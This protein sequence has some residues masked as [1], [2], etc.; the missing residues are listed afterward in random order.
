MTHGLTQ[1]FSAFLHRRRRLGH[2]GRPALL[3]TVAGDGPFA[4]T[5]GH[6]ARDL[7][8]VACDD[9]PGAIA[10]LASHEGGLSTAEAAARL[11]RDGPNDV[12]HEKPLPWWLHL[13]HCYANPF[14]LLLT[15]LAVVSLA[16]D[17][18]KATVVIGVMVVLSTVVRFVQEGRSS[19][20]AEG[21]KVW[22]ATRPP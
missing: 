22:W 1:W 13:W 10:R 7:L 4:G 3:D 16:S 21:L 6:L 5:P 18:A 2:F 9:V 8:L 11:T 19:R 15:V 17:D 20:A 12:A 14:N